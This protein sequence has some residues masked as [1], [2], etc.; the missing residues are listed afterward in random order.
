MLR[1]VKGAVADTVGDKEKQAFDK[2]AVIALITH[3]G[4]DG[5]GLFHPY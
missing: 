2:D 1:V 5:V 4:Q 3:F